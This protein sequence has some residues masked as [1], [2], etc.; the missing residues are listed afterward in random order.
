MFFFTLQLYLFVNIC[1][2]YW[3]MCSTS[4]LCYS[5]ICR[6]LSVQTNVC[7]R[8]E[9][10]LATCFAL[11]SFLAYSST[12]KM[13]A[14]CSSEKS[15]DTQRTARRY[16]PGDRILLTYVVCVELLSIKLKCSDCILC[17]LVI[18]RSLLSTTLFLKMTFSQI[19][20]VTRRLQKRN[21]FPCLVLLSYSF[22]YILNK[23]Q[24]DRVA[25]LPW[26][27]TGHIKNDT[28]N[29]SSIVAC[30]FITAVTFLPSRCLATIGGFLSIRCLA[31]IKGF[32]PSRCLATIG[33]TQTASW[34]HKH[35]FI[36]SK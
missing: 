8:F 34:S 18:C 28:S 2:L 10:L 30:V 9:S 26:Y 17:V 20:D 11:L 19:R 1:L 29:N 14:T 35:T 5:P 21:H 25:Y 31:T 23:M 6:V 27:D 7:V 24:V 22:L 36:F 15:V 13:E 16:F 3:P 33:D 32:L 12:Q 4:C